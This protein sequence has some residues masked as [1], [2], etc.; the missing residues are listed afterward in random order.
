MAIRM[1]KIRMTQ[2]HPDPREQEIAVKTSIES[3]P[4]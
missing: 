1:L 3:D 4:P 2:Q